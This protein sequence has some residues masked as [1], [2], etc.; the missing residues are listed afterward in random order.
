V[1]WVCGVCG[2]FHEETLRDIRLGLPDPVFALDD[3]ARERRVEMN[4]DFCI[5]SDS[6]ESLRFFVRGLLHAPIRRDG[7]GLGPEDFRYGVWV[8]VD[9]EGYRRLGERW[10]DERGHEAAPVFGRLANELSSYP[11]TDGLAAALQLREVRILPAVVL[12]EEAHPLAEHQR[13]G[14]DEA[15]ANHLAESVLH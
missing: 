1:G 8:E 15:Q 10:H 13:L 5:F 6:P 11:G 14:I 2:D 9:A 12:M 7:N 4:D 3:E